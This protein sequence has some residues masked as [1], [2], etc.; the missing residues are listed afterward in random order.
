MLVYIDN[1]TSPLHLEKKTLQLNIDNA[2]VWAQALSLFQSI[3][4]SLGQS[5]SHDNALYIGNYYIIKCICLMIARGQ[6]TVS[7]YC[8]PPFAC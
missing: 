5:I 3:L 7:D 4:L 1:F 8:V 6:G 2:L